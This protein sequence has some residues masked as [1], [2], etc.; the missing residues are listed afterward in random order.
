MS[1]NN[2]APTAI[3]AQAEANQADI[4][5]FQFNIDR[6][7]FANTKEYIHYLTHHVNNSIHKDGRVYFSMKNGVLCA[8]SVSPFAEKFWQNI[9]PGILPIVKALHDKRYL[10]YSSCEGHDLDF[11]RYVGLAFCDEESRKEVADYIIKQNIKGVTVKYFSTVSNNQVVESDVTG[12]PVPTKTSTEVKEKTS[13]ELED[14]TLSFNVQFH[15]NYSS[16]CF[17]EVIVYDEISYKYEGI[18]KEIKKMFLR[19]D[20]KRNQEKSTKI[21]AEKLNLSEFKKYKF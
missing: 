17:L 10:T 21:L 13:Q 4:S 20:K 9:E 8:N 7:S 1:R 12:K 19:Y 2:L 14:E 16:Y 15:R 11:R 6:K 3:F 18:W 5:S